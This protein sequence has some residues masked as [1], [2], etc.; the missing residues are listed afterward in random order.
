MATVRGVL[1][2]GWRLALA[3]AGLAACLALAG[4]AAGQAGENPKPSE[5]AQEQREKDKFGLGPALWLAVRDCNQQELA[6]LLRAGAEP[7]FRY[8]P[9][10]TTPLMETVASY[11][12]TCPQEMAQQLIRAGAQVNLR[13]ERGWTA[14]HFVA[15][16]HCLPSHMKALRYLLRQGADPTIAAE[17]QTTPLEMATRADCSEARGVL[18]EYIQHL[19]KL[20][21]A[22]QRAPWATPPAEQKRP[23]QLEAGPAAA[24]ESHLPWMKETGGGSGQSSGD[25]AFGQPLERQP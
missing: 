15:V 8:G 3:A 6:K 2:R 23:R 1:A 4:C 9:L 7:N 17:D 21:Q 12:N 19:H 20:E 10:L 11:D 25:P 18:A 16:G 13:D 24:D 5:Q 14:L 22:A